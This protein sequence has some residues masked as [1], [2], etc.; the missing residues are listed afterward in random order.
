MPSLDANEVTV[1]ITNY[2]ELIHDCESI[3][4]ICCLLG[5]AED[6]MERWVS[7]YLSENIKVEV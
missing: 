7:E 3:I 6:Q 4:E 2:D 5:M 1:R